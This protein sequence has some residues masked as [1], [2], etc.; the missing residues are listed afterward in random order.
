M[1]KILAR[2]LFYAAL[3]LFFF[4][5]VSSRDLHFK[6]RDQLVS[7]GQ[8]TNN[9]AQEKVIESSVLRLK[10]MDQ[11]SEA[12]CEHM[13]GFLPCSENFFGHLFLILVY[14]YLLVHGETYLLS[15]GGRIFE[16]LGTGFFGASGFPVIAQLPESLILLVTG[17]FSSDEG[18]QE[19]VLTGVGMVAG[20]TIFNLTIL[21]G[22]CLYCGRQVF[23]P[24][25]DT[26]PPGNNS[27]AETEKGKPPTLWTGYGVGSDEET[28]FTAKVM[29]V[30]LIPLIILVLPKIFGIPYD[31]RIYKIFIL[32]TLIALAVTLA[33]YF[34]YQ[35]SHKSIQARRLDYLKVIH[36][37]HVL[38]VIQHVQE[39]VPELVNEHGVPNEAAILSLFKKLDKD[40]DKQ[41]SSSELK[42]LFNKI[43]LMSKASVLNRERI[44]DNFWKE[45]DHDGD[46]QIS[47][48]EFLDTIKHWIHTVCAVDVSTGHSPVP[49]QPIKHLYEVITL[50]L[51]KEK[52]KN[53]RKKFL[54]AVQHTN[55]GDPDESAIVKLF[56][57]LDVDK[58][59]R[60]TLTELKA[61]LSDP[62]IDEAKRAA[63]HE[64]MVKIFND[65]DKDKD[66]EISLEEFTKGLKNWIKSIG[67]NANQYKVDRSAG[68][69]LKAISLL[70]LGIAMLAVLAEPLI[71]S[72]QKFSSSANI[73]SFYVAFILVPFATSARTTISAIGAVREKI[74]K[75]TRL[76]FSEIYD[77]VFMN[78][79]LGFS[80]L[81]F[82]VCFRGVI[83]HF[84]AEV[85]IVVIVCSI[86]GLIASFK[87]RLPVWIMFIAYA[88]YP[89]S[90]L[91]VYFVDDYF[92]SP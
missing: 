29:L 22:I 25:T 41:L 13:Y 8:V 80:V 16:I 5:E 72:V 73:P 3:L 58:N 18:A 14:E 7:D 47:Y 77:A 62:S 1:A 90:L 87:S 51:E 89:L 85:M 53:V 52:M 69:W 50:V 2:T 48:Q 86:M 26:R 57:V 71:H 67:A 27:S 54:E 35:F 30:S 64:A 61:L 32:V 83:W 15:G 92:L 44:I 21:W 38:A 79:V 40:G 10:G 4:N 74:P 37:T 19:N 55:D 63:E 59:Q 45:F 91:L 68:A 20:S 28:R 60:L 17:L 9:A 6:N 12:Q 31:S 81:L 11:S 39:C 66:G 23:V 84:S 36:Q 65:L 82:V 78:N 34:F 75:S 70:V 56:E 43:R 88:L 42:E 49:G 46:E 76:T 33:T 24:K